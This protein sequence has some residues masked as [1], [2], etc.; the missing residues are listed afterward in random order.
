M[1]HGH[2]DEPPQ[3][4]PGR[5]ALGA[6]ESA[7][8]RA[9][10]SASGAPLPAPPARERPPE[11]ADPTPD[12][13]TVRRSDRWLIAS[14][15]VVAALVVVGAIALAVSLG[16]NPRISAPPPSAAARASTTIAGRQGGAGTTGPSHSTSTSRPTST[17]TTTTVPSTPGAAPV[18]SSLTPSSGNA[19]QGIQV[20][21]SNFMS[22]DGQ[23][24]ATFNGQVAPTSC[25][26]QNTCTIT[27]PPPPPGSQSAQVT[28]TTASGTS[29][30]VTFTYG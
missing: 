2:A 24:V 16:N 7:V 10:E 30:A 22:S 29:N 4:T 11:P 17:T 9:R 15:A 8:R 5:R 23:I 19:G 20:A 14:V 18:I 12:P 13:H 3:G 26:A 1:T 27:V 25:P 28:I 6:M 21:G